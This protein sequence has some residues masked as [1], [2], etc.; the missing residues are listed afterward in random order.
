MPADTIPTRLLDRARDRASSP[1]YFARGSDGWVATTWSTYAQEVRTAARAL[2]ALGFRPGDKVCILGFNRPEWAIFDLAAM[3][4][5]GAPAGIYTTCSPSE[6]QYIVH[7]TESPI[8]LVENKAQWEKLWKEKDQLP[9]LRTI[10]LMRGAGTVDDPKA[11]SWEAFLQKADSVPEASLDERIEGLRPDDLATLIYTSGTTGPPKGVMLSHTNLRWTADC[12]RGMLPLE[13]SDRTLSYLPLSHIAEQMF[14]LHVPISTGYQVYFARSM[15][16]L[17]DDLVDVQPTVMFA[18]PRIWEKF[19]AAVSAGLKTAPP[20]RQKIAGWAMGVGRQVHTLK[21]RGVEPSGWLALQYSIAGK[22]VYSKAK[23][24]LGLGQAKVCVVGAAPIARE[25]LEFFM[26]LDV[27]IREVYGQSEDSGPTSFN[28]PGRTRTGTVGPIIPG[29]EVKIASDE[30][31]VVRGPNVFLGYYKDAAATSEAL[32]AG[33]LH[34]GDLGRIDGEGFLHITGR[35]KDI[36]ITAG[37]KN[38]APK[39]IEGALKQHPFIG[40][41]VVIGDRR[42]YLVALVS[43]DPDAIAAWAKAQGKDPAALSEDLD[44]R[45]QIQTH[46]DTVVNPDLARVEQVKKFAILKSPLSIDAGELTPTLKVK[47]AAVNRLHAGLIDGLYA[48]GE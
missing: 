36:L 12:A 32:V 37:G 41:A 34:S 25:I 27:P 2:I 9:Q 13:A 24:K 44:L 14:T 39:N 7:H 6:V 40:E 43:L 3:M 21:N 10:V 30:E 15:E 20:L 16:L 42:P 4:A 35:K 28:L 45:G 1:A 18:V 26:G 31:I 19:H 22:L 38:I 47:R 23:P 29:V 11:L 46:L 33:W 17:K 48:G 8:V 5:G